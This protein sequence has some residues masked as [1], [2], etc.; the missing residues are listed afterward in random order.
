MERVLSARDI[1]IIGARNGI[2][3]GVQVGSYLPNPIN[4]NI[5][6]K[7]R[8][9]LTCKR[10]CVLDFVFKVE[11]G[12]IIS[13]MDTRVGSP[14]ARDANLLPQFETQTTLHRSLNAGRVRLN[15]IAI[16]AATVVGHVDEIP[17]HRVAFFELAKI[18]NYSVLLRHD[19]STQ[20]RQLLFPTC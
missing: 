11:M 8:I 2:E 4:Y 17:R 5:L 6:G 18:R 10:F 1:I 15:L 19:L 7:K 9:H 20:R 13:G 12:V 3:T 14:A 16:V